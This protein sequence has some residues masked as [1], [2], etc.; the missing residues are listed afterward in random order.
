MLKVSEIVVISFQNQFRKLKILISR[1]IEQIFVEPK[2]S[3]T[4]TSRKRSEGVRRFLRL[5]YMLQH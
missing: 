2:I 3:L 4:T 1:L 5:T